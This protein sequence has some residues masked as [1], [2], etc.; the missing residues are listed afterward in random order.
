[1]RPTFNPRLAQRA[2]TLVSAHLELRPLSFQDIRAGYLLESAD[3]QKLYK[4]VAEPELLEALIDSYGQ[5]VQ[6][7]VSF[8]VW[9]TERLAI[10][11]HF[12]S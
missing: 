1:M 12:H 7:I 5:S 8:Q 2:P 10:A 6:A 11:R 9:P 3:R 4:L